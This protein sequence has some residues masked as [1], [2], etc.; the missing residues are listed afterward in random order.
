M[1]FVCLAGEQRIRHDCEPCCVA[2]IK[3][4]ARAAHAGAEPRVMAHLGVL[5]RPSGVAGTSGPAGCG[6]PG[7][8]IPFRGEWLWG[9]DDRCSRD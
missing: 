3:E 6:D 2:K 4:A 8:G 1:A 5:T 7:V 9:T